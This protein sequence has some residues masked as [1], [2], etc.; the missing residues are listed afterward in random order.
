MKGQLRGKGKINEGVEAAIFSR[1]LRLE[2]RKVSCVKAEYVEQLRK[3]VSLSGG[4][5][6][7]PLGGH[8]CLSL[9][10]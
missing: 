1:T 10:P 6:T 9:L 5:Y 2:I 8:M 3:S 4:F 7:R